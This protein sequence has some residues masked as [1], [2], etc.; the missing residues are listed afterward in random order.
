MDQKLLETGRTDS[1]ST[2]AQSKK[3][4]K[5][6]KNKIEGKFGI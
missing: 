5:K 2:D 4:K 3:K 6:K 1:D